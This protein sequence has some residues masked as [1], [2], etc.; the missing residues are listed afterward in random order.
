MTTVQL[1]EL[2][3]LDEL[4]HRVT[5]LST[6]ELER[7]VPFVLKERA[8]RHAHSLPKNEAELL[9]KINAGLSAEVQNRYDELMQKQLLAQLS[10]TEQIEL[11]NLIDQIEQSDAQ[12]VGYLAQLANLHGVSLDVVMQQLGIRTRPYA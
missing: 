3:T 11:L 8:S 4:V 9:Q 7:F 1:Q 2:E 10:N 12:R 6:S 5:H